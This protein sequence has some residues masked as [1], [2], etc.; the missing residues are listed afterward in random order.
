MFEVSIPPPPPSASESL[1][2]L[3]PKGLLPLQADLSVVQ[4]QEDVHV[5]APHAKPVHRGPK[6]VDRARWV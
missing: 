2:Y 3:L 1:V 5:T 4:V 6:L